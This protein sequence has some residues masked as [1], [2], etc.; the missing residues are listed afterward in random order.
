MIKKLKGIKSL[1]RI[2]FTGTKI[3]AKFPVK[4]DLCHNIPDKLE[5]VMGLN[6]I[7]PNLSKT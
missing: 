3:A 5:E 1:Q 2:S 7:I 6:A 4:N